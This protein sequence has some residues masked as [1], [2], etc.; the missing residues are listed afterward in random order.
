MGQNVAVIKEKAKTVGAALEAMKP[1]LAAALP[2]HLTAERLSR[3]VMTAVQQTPR[4]LDCDRSSLFSAVMTCAQLG[5]EPDGTLGQAYL[6]P[7]GSKVQFIPGY[8]GY[9]ALARNSGEVETIQAHQVYKG[10]VFEY[11]YGLKEDLRHVPGEDVDRSDDNITHFYAY[12]KFKDGGGHIFEVLTKA[13]V[14]AVRDNSD[15]YKAF[16]ANRIKDNPWHSHYAQMGRKTAI[17][18]LANYL[19]MN[20]Q[21]AA[22]LDAAFDRG[23]HGEITSE[24]DIVIDS[25]AVEVP[26]EDPTGAQGA[27]SKLDEIANMGTSEKPASDEGKKPEAP[28]K[29]PTMTAIK[30]E[31]AE[32]K[33]ADDVDLILDRGLGH[34]TDD[35]RDKVVEAANKRKAA[36]AVAPPASP[37]PPPPAAPLQGGGALFGDD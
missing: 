4:L 1:Q 36:L 3:V 6:V 30:K 13:E 18:R 37:P 12:A 27:T 31:I 33:T 22:A 2:K 23:Q 29:P 26:Q 5:L 11:A 19:P 25:E 14:D 17:R 20:V 28:A 32:A 15:G 10:D 21:R 24:G 7:F 9:L 8:K 16:K 34:L 35:H